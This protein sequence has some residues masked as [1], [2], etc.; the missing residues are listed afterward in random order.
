[1][2]GFPEKGVPREEVLKR[3]EEMLA[4]DPVAWKQFG[5]MYRQPSPHPFAYEVF[6]KNLNRNSGD[7]VAF[8]GTHDVEVEV[9]AMLG[10][11]F[12]AP[13]A[14][15][16]IVTGGAEANSVAMHV[17]RNMGGKG[18]PEVILPVTAHYDFEVSAEILGLKPVYIGVDK[19]YRAAPEEVE[20]AVNKNTVAVV[21]T[22]GTT[23][24]GV[25]DP[26]EEIGS[27]TEKHGLFLHVDAAF[28]GFVL[29][30]LKGSRYPA[31]HFDFNVNGVSSV[32]ADPHKMGLTP[33]PGG[34]ILLRQEDYLKCVLGGH[35]TFTSSRSGGSVAAIWAL[36][37]LMGKEGYEKAV[38]KCVDLTHVLAEGVEA[39]DG[40]AIVAEPTM[41]ILGVKSDS[42]DMVKLAGELR[43]AGYGFKL[44][45]LPD[46]VQCIRFVVQDHIEKE[47]VEALL[48]VMERAV[49]V[50]RSAR[51]NPA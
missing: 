30:F 20:K 3:L 17:A 4:K 14:A 10:S 13:K 24:L 2:A 45:K 50:V 12:G 11:L 6:T 38:L 41:N 22:A 23:A 43:K 35:F 34:G 33:I 26:V 42:V 28:G 51:L 25:V 32:T 46:G 9:V 39:I 7:T 5:S 1:M 29:P 27:I 36:F 44:F 19:D 37:K 15:G 8:P 47:H 49:H 31:P 18:K 40:L 21:C 16:A 48:E